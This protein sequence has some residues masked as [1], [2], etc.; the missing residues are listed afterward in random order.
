MIRAASTIHRSAQFPSLFGAS[1]SLSQYQYKRRPCTVRTQPRRGT[2][3]APS[4]TVSTAVNSAREVYTTTAT[5]DFG[6][7]FQSPVAPI[8]YVFDFDQT[9]LRIHSFGSRIKA[10]CAIIASS[11]N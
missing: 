1:F 3:S 2:V 10:Q 5:M 6:I 11:T 9:I 8:L 4:G 7:D